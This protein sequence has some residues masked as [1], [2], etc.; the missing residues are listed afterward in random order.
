MII[1]KK[2][3]NISLNKFFIMIII[4][5]SYLNF[6]NNQIGAVPTAPAPRSYGQLLESQANCRTYEILQKCDPNVNEPS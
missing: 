2:L 6:S 1:V 3:P 4:N 5:K